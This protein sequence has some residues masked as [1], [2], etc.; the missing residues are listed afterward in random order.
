MVYSTE[1]SR[2][3][4]T[5]FIFVIDQSYSMSDPFDSN[6]TE[7][8]SK[9]EELAK[10]INLQLELLVDRCA[11]G[12][13]ILDRFDISVIGYGENVESALKGDLESKEL[14]SISQIAFNPLRIDTF[15]K[16]ESDGSGGFVERIHQ[17]SVWVDPVSI[18]GTPMCKALQKVKN[19]LENWIDEHPNSYPPTVI[20]IT[21]GESTDG[22]PSKIASEIRAMKTTDGNVCLFNI[23]LTSAQL[24]KLAFLD[25]T[26]KLTDNLSRMLFGISSILP[27]PIYEEA[28]SRGHKIS[29]NARG[30]AYNAD[31]I[32]VIEFLQIGT[33][34]R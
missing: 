27:K 22:D 20:H 7:T 34:T 2:K 25:S 14:V 1:I 30:F 10:S 26:E 28:I 6:A 18:N 4:P 13:D 17:Y 33:R 16:K 29:E 12:E 9:A 19:I 24:P 23:H 3:N 5:C 32:D 31:L 15:K 21:D 8:R 11:L